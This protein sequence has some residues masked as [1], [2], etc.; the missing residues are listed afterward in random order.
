MT[1]RTTLPFLLALLGGAG[2][3]Q[4]P[5]R[6]ADAGSIKPTRVASLEVANSDTSIGG[7]RQITLIEYVVLMHQANHCAVD[8]DCRVASAFGG[9]QRVYVNKNTDTTMLSNTW[10]E[11]FGRLAMPNCLTTVGRLA[12]RDNVCVDAQT[13]SA[14]EGCPL[15]RAALDQ[16]ASQ[17]DP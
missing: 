13:G 1:I 17:G 2:C 6:D 8:S 3:P 4:R 5:A 14:Y 11:N 10:N 12:C 9:C 16:K 7:R 15:C